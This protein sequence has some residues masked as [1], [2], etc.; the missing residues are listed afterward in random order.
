MGGRACSDQQAE[1]CEDSLRTNCLN[2]ALPQEQ[3]Y[4]KQIPVIL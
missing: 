1:E 2:N 4:I 3:R